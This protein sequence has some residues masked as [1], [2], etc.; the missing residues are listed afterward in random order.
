MVE[1]VFKCHKCGT[2]TDIALDPPR[3]TICENCC[4]DHEYKY[5][6][7][8]QKH[9]CIHCNAQRPYDW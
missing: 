5:D 9:L 1:P 2:A 6:N 3:L 8:E 4:E 7:Y